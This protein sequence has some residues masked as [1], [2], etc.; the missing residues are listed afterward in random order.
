MVLNADIEDLDY[1][2]KDYSWVILN[3]A[4]EAVPMPGVTTTGTL[5]ADTV[6]LNISA[7]ILVA[8][9]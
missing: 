3:N 6:S 9:R 1:A 5:S 4:G 2:T 8:S 7:G